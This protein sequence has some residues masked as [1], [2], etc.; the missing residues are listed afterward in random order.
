MTFWFIALSG[1]AF[2]VGADIP[3]YMVE[4]DS[5][6]VKSINSISDILNFKDNRQPLWVL[7]EYVCHLISPN[8]VLFK[9]VIAI[10]CNLTVSRFILKHSNYPFISLLFF[11]LLLYLNLN[12]NALRQ[13]LAIALFLMGYDFMV[14]KKWIKYYTFAIGAFLFHFSAFILFFLPLLHFISINK[15]SI[16]IIAIAL[17]VGVFIILQFDLLSV[18]YDFSITYSEFFTEEASTLTENY[19]GRDYNSTKAN[20]NGMILIALQVIVVIFIIIFNMRYSTNNQSFALKI[21]LIYAVFIILNRAIPIV[22]TRLMQYF[23]IFYCCML[24][25]AFMALCK[26]MTKSKIIPIFIIILFSI[27]P[28]QTLVRENKQ[29]GIPL[30]VQYSPYYS[31]FNPKIDPVRNAYFGSFQ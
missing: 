20:I 10:I 31:V 3:R 30:I 29:T 5:F 11:G 15:R 22:F 14:D 24:P 26:S 8:F 17:V 13:F 27:Q 16:V 21:L 6:S 9:I 7:L 28:I 23:D 12:F 19:F 1:F 25:G 4:Y 2:Q 18:F